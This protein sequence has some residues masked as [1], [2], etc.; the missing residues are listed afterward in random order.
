MKGT[1]FRPAEGMSEIGSICLCQLSKNMVF[2]EAGPA[3]AR[4]LY[5]AQRP[6]S[7]ICSKNLAYPYICAE[8]LS[9]LVPR[10]RLVFAF[11]RQDST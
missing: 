1:R 4:D 6:D 7:A 3:R 2:S 10:L 8:N 11:G 5:A 9:R